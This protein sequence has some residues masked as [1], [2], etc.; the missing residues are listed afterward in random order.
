M[1]M[2]LGLNVKHNSLWCVGHGKADEVATGHREEN[3]D[4]SENSIVGKVDRQELA[5]LDVAEHQ[6]RDKH[7]PGDNQRREQ[8][9]LFMRLQR[10]QAG[11]VYTKRMRCV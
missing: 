1:N 4:D 9:R 5:R 10:R 6:Q 2:H 7:H 8:T 11:S 3:H